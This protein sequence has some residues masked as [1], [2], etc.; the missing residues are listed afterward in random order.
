MSEFEDSCTALGVE[1]DELELV[2][3][4]FVGDPEPKKDQRLDAFVGLGVAEFIVVAW[5][6]SNKAGIEF[7]RFGD[8][9]GPAET[10][11]STERSRMAPAVL[12]LE[13][14]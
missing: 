7:R 3:R 6:K 13:P 12:G 4:A 14:L 5:L 1:S 9:V 8:M 11:C 2:G 10:I